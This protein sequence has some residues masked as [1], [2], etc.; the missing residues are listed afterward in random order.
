MADDF[1][2]QYNSPDMG[3]QPSQVYDYDMNGF[4]AS[5]GDQASD[6]HYPDTFKKP[7]HPTFSDESI[8]HGK[9]GHEGGHWDLLESNKFAFTPGATNLKQHST[10]ELMNYFKKVEPNN[11][12]NLPGS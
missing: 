1:T 9:D 5:Q 7:N 4:L 10:Q 11:I 8:Y 12:L 2:E 3:A 6:G